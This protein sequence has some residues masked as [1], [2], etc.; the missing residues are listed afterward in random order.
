MTGIIIADPGGQE[1]FRDIFKGRPIGIEW[2]DNPAEVDSIK[3]DFVLDLTF[4]PE[5][6]RLQSL[7]NS[8]APLI[9]LNSVGIPLSALDVDERFI[10]INGWNTF[11]QRPLA[12]VVVPP[13]TLS[14]AEQFFITWSKPFELLA[15]LPG[16]PSARIVSMIINEA[17]LALGEGVGTR[18]SIDTAM[19]LG[20]NYP[21]GP[22]EWCR[23]IGP[24]I[25]YNL[26]EILQ[27]DN[28]RYNPAPLL[29]DE[30]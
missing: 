10:R 16:T 1:I 26:L 3:T 15:D 11:L 22:F 2:T 13:A 8:E 5:P 24:K 9:L 21:Y 30:A 28:L 12:E 7:R 27:L 6:G 19:K 20:T 23:L 14:R 4:S 17:Y 18:E 25:V 29:R